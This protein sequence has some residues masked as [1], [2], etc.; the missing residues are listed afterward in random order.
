MFIN[1]L[2]LAL[3]GI[4]IPILYKATTAIANEW[5]HPKTINITQKGAG[6]VTLLCA[7]LFTADV[8][9]FMYFIMTTIIDMLV[10]IASI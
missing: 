5:F 10:L 6:F 9:G 2:F 8:A 3:T 7:I 1:A 4:L